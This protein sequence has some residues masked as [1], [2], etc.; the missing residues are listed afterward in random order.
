MSSKESC[1]K[2][3]ARIWP[4]WIEENDGIDPTT[5]RDEE[6]LS[7]MSLSSSTSGTETDDMPLTDI[8]V[9]GC[10]VL[11]VRLRNHETR[12]G[13]DFF[14]GRRVFF[15]VETFCNRFV[16][17]LL[18]MMSAAARALQE[19]QKPSRNTDVWD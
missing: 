13:P 18:F 10:S 9:N 15:D 7:S 19:R 12:L 11:N 6:A 3:F 2:C 14:V 5:D 1:A 16:S 17:L 8:L 4:E